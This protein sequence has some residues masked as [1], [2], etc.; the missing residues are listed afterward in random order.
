MSDVK[1]TEQT[2]EEIYSFYRNAGTN[3]RKHFN[4]SFIYKNFNI[5]NENSQQIFEAIKNKGVILSKIKIE[6]K[7][8]IKSKPITFKIPPPARKFPSVVY[9]EAGNATIYHTAQ[10]AF[11]DVDFFSDDP[12]LSDGSNKT[13]IVG[14]YVPSVK[15]RRFQKTNSVVVTE[16][17]R[18]ALRNSEVLMG[19]KGLF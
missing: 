1:Q 11:N 9:D 15:P 18:E 2:I 7:G 8:I 17:Q 10:K 19:E 12:I 4:K 3:E 6:G 5:N 14:E 16:E 13:S